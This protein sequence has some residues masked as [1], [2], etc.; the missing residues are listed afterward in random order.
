MAEK[1]KDIKLE[2]RVID[3]LSGGDR[4]TTTLVL[5]E[6]H[7]WCLKGIQSRESHLNRKNINMGDVVTEAIEMY[8]NDY[9]KKHNVVIKDNGTIV[10]VAK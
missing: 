4:R 6:R 3:L 7:Y 8:K 2:E 1:D 10:E 5:L 9:E